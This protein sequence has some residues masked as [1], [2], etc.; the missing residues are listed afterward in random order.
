MLVW[1]CRQLSFLFVVNPLTGRI[2]LLGVG[3]QRFSV[4][5]ALLFPFIFIKVISIAGF[6]AALCLSY[7]ILAY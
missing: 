4:A 7:G 1:G 2:S 3:Y 6:S 5:V